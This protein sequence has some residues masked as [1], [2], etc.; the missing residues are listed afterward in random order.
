MSDAYVV[1]DAVRDLVL[2]LIILAGL[3]FGILIAMCL[4]AS[5]IY[6]AIN[7]LASAVESLGKE[8]RNG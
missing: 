7:R 5:D 4:W 6:A 3:L 8:K 1:A 2:P